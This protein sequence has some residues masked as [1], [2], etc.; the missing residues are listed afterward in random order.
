[1]TPRPACS[2][3]SEAGKESLAPELTLSAR[4]GCKPVAMDG[5]QG[6][7]KGG[8]R[9]RTAHGREAWGHCGRGRSRGARLGQIIGSSGRKKCCALRHR[10]L[11]THWIEA[12]HEL[13]RKPQ[14]KSS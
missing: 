2:V 5:C 9:N 12:H 7:E 3:C 11:L 6:G 13:G 14:E 10:G 1:M 4:P 8:D